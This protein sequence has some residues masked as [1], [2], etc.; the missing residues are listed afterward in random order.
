[1]EKEIERLRKAIE[2]KLGWGAADQWHS[3]MFNE[4]S[5]QIFKST[6]ISLSVTTLKRFFGAVNYT[7]K[8][9]ITT[10]DAIAQFLDFENWRDFKQQNQSS[11]K[12]RFKL[13]NKKGVY[14]AFG[15]VLCFFIISLV[16]NRQPEVVINSSE[17]TFGSEVKSMEYPNTVVFDFS[18]PKDLKSDSLLIQQSWD[19]TKTVPVKADQTQATAIYYIPGYFRAKLL[20]EGEIV[21]EH[22]LFLKSNG[23]LATIDYMPI[24]RYFDLDEQS[25]EGYAIPEAMR[26]EMNLA[27]EPVISSFHY[28]DDLGDV[29]DEQFSL[30]ATVENLSTQPWAVCKRMSIYLL[31]SEG[32]LAIPFSTIG[33]SSE[34]NIMMNDVYLSGKEHDLSALSNDF[35]DP[36]K[37]S[38]QVQMKQMSVSIDD[39]LV[40]EGAYNA[41][42]GKLVGFRFRFLGIGQVSDL[43]LYGNN[44]Q[45][46][47]LD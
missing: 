20:V 16:A 6:N 30:S 2:K 36:T 40:F 5:E 47:R 3:S 41:S 27:E 32:A 46:I 15:F 44:Q 34:S 35:Q 24:P 38:V 45:E 31:G 29:T 22:D 37:I 4:L 7:G 9:S 39:E 13:P 19:A 21:K 1:M 42:I 26:S 28:V 12:P 18:M 8:P 43:H 17:F 14:A 33:C 23:W 11:V 10:L 25:F